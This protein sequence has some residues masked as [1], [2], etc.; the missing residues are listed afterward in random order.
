VAWA[1]QEEPFSIRQVDLVMAGHFVG[2][3][4]RL[5]GLGPIYVP[6]LGWFPGD[7]GIMGLQRI[8]SVNQYVTGGLGASTFYPMPGRLF[9]P[10]SAALLTFTARIE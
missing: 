3:Q 4:W 7:T 8:N 5:F 2:G 1:S 10:P 9:N 6:E